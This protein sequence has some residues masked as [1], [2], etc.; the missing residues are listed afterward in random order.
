M[1][2]DRYGE[3]DRI[4][5]GEP[6]I[7]L[8]EIVS[9]L[10]PGLALDLGCGEGG[11]TV[12]L[13]KHGW[14]VTAVDIADTALRRAPEASADLLQYI[15]FQQHDLTKTFPEGEYDLV[16]A[17]F[18]HS[19]TEWDRDSVMRRAAA[20]VAPGGVLL[21]VDHG[22]APPWAPRLHH[23]EFPSAEE[24]VD[25]MALDPGQWERVRVDSAERQ[26]QRPDG[27][28]GTLLDNIIVLR[29]TGGGSPTGQNSKG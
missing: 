20:A 29:R 3:S 22:A 4:W 1:W 17:H 16:S 7:R 6:N 28:A 13:A 24:V 27:Q 21:V 19:P 18:L 14:R 2:E 25:A 26:A 8:V 9:G 12:W 11:D 5:S 15:D 23:H 10:A